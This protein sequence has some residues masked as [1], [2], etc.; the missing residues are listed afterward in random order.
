MNES[1]K[2]NLVR[3]TIRL[4]TELHREVL[5]LCAKRAVS[6]QSVITKFL[7]G[8]VE[9]SEENECVKNIGT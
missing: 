9:F 5:I 3:T 1:K 2:N 7:E 4:P 8:Y 6:M